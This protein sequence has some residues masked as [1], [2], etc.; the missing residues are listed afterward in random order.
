MSFALDINFE[1]TN[2]FIEEVEKVD[3]ENSRQDGPEDYIEDDDFVLEV[4]ARRK[5]SRTEEEDNQ[6]DLRAVLSRRRN[7]R[8]TKAVNL[9]ENMPTRLVQSAFQGLGK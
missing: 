5:K 8:L 3:L 9:Q 1:E 4:S 7:E 6:S 2:K